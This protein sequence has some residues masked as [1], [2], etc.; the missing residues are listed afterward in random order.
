[1]S[2]GTVFLPLFLGAI[3]AGLAPW[4]VRNYAQLGHPVLTRTNPG[5]ELRIS[6]ND[7]ADANE[8]VNLHKRLYQRYHPLQSKTE[9][10]R[11]RA[12]GEVEYNRRAFAEAKAWIRSRPGRFL[13]LTVGRIKLFWFPEVDALRSVLL[14]GLSVG[15]LGGT[16]LLIRQNLASGLVLL[17]PLM[18]YPLP[19]YLVHSMIRHRSPIDWIG[20][21]GAV[22]LLAAALGVQWQGSRLAHD[23]GPVT[24]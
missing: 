9:A 14:G 15:A 13:E 19:H 3:A 16:F 1:M 22:L 24:H 6:N 2:E 10:E 23:H 4:G 18:I 7:L 21:F 5:L 8:K 12:L 20:V 11:V 17:L